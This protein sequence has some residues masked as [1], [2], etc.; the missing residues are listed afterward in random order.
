[1]GVALALVLS[2]LLPTQVAVQTDETAETDA[3]LGSVLVRLLDEGYRIAPD[4]EESEAILQLS[5]TAD[6]GLRVAVRTHLLRSARVPP[7]PTELEHLEVMQHA[8]SLTDDLEVFRDDE[9]EAL[10]VGVALNVGGEPSDSE[11]HAV[12]E[13]LAGELYRGAHPLAPRAILG[14]RLL[15]VFLD[16]SGAGVSVSDDLRCAPPAV[17]VLRDA[18]EQTFF[19]DVAGA[20]AHLLSPV[21][22]QKARADRRARPEPDRDAP[23]TVEERFFPGTPSLALA[24]A[25]GLMMGPEG[26]RPTLFL[27]AHP[28]L[29]KN[30][31]LTLT[32]FLADT[33]SSGRGQEVGALVGPNLSLPLME[34]IRL[35]AALLSGV[36]VEAARA[37]GA[38]WQLEPEVRLAGQLALSL[39][40]VEDVLTLDGGGLVMVDLGTRGYSAKNPARITDVLRPA[41][42]IGVTWH[43]GGS[44]NLSGAQ[45]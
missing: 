38:Q 45:R 40:L 37:P 33:E 2:S 5:S 16:D 23:P 29:G 31:G 8:V 19:D 3:L 34:G 10:P 36:A 43:F 35:N 24:S 28:S 32:G 26:V 14:D 18:D 9:D 4:P 12:R 41:A 17:Y 21:P 39:P 27:S 15:C 30:V 13:H 42:F 44:G 7:G 22:A 6:G 25:G 1:M 20:A 11:R